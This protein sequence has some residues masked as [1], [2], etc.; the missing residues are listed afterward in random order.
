MRA[1]RGPMISFPVLFLFCMLVGP[2]DH[3]VLLSSFVNIYG[4]KFQVFWN[5]MIDLRNRLKFKLLLTDN[6]HVHQRS[7]MDYIRHTHYKNG[8][9]V[10]FELMPN[11]SH[12]QVSHDQISLTWNLT[13]QAFC[14][15]IGRNKV[16]EF[17]TT[18]EKKMNMGELFL[19]GKTCNLCNTRCSTGSS[20]VV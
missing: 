19:Y 17:G 8:A 2:H 11:L 3:M 6:L 5:H 16:I 14:V 20:E 1:C 4:D 15:P 18:W 12:S 7:P 13:S 10:A 9:L